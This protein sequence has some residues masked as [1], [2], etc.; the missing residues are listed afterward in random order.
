M[1]L[2]RNSALR[3]IINSDLEWASD[4]HFHQQHTSTSKHLPGWRI[5][6]T[7]HYCI[8]NINNCFD[9]GKCV[10]V[11]TALTWQHCDKFSLFRHLASRSCVHSGKKPAEHEVFRHRS[12]L[13]VAS[14]CSE[15]VSELE[16]SRVCWLFAMQRQL[17][18]LL[19]LQNTIASTRKTA[20]ILFLFQG[21]RKDNLNQIP[22]MPPE[23]TQNHMKKTMTCSPWIKN[24]SQK[25]SDIHMIEI[26]LWQLLT[27]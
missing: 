8:N 18:I 9:H 11:L 25:Q 19:P 10:L 26:V 17:Q 22:L 14:R 3:W 1:H 16:L 7:D 27:S 5:R 21:S 13:P 6:K 24:K 4:L 15:C 2:F 20:M 12:P 23:H